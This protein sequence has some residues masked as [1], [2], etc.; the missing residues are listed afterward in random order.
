MEVLESL[1]AMLSS[2]PDEAV[3]G[4]LSSYDAAIRVSGATA[5]AKGAQL[6]RQAAVN[7]NSKERAERLIRAAE[8]VSCGQPSSPL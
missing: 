7:A 2:L 4:I 5:T 6:L 1:A 3:E 8:A